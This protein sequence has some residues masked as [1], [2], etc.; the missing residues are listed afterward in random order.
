MK[1]EATICIEIFTPA[2]QI[3][4]LNIP[5]FCNIKYLKYTFRNRV[6]TELHSVRLCCLWILGQTGF[7]ETQ[8]FVL[9]SNIVF[10][11][12]DL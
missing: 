8:G 7:P 5:E 2:I 10:L 4:Q 12:K 1:K 6:R 3:V 11:N 9:I